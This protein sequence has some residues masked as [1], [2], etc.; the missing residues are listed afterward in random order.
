MKTNKFWGI[1]IMMMLVFCTSAML[2][3]CCKEDDELGN[4]LGNENGTTSGGGNGQTSGDENGNAN[5]QDIIKGISMSSIAAEGTTDPVKI[6]FSAP[7]AWSAS[8]DSKYGTIEPTSGSAGEKC[9]IYVNIKKNTSFSSRVIPV[10]INIEGNEPINVEL[11]Q[12]VGEI[13]TKGTSTK[14]VDGKEVKQDWVQLWE[15]GPK[16]AT[17]NV[18]YEMTW[19]EAVKQGKD[20][21][22]GPNW[23]TP[24][25]QE[26]SKLISFQVLVWTNHEY[27]QVDGVWGLKFTGIDEYCKGNTIFIPIIDGNETLGNGFYWTSTQIIENGPYQ[28]DATKAIRYQALHNKI[29]GCSCC[30]PQVKCDLKSYVRPVLVE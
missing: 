16:F 29:N 28:F 21:V 6:E 17:E 5:L 9:T 18:E 7:K 14:I 30:F 15:D 20:Y 8:M 11:T 10:T 13:I 2:N 3:S 1:V 12:E 4:V 19:N 27:C 24:S 25:Y 22:W 26:I 23:R